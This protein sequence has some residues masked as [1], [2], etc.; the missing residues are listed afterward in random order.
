[1][2][3][4]QATG[5]VVSGEARREVRCISSSCTEG[6]EQDSCAVTQVPLA[7]WHAQLLLNT[8]P[9][10]N[11]LFSTRSDNDDNLAT[12]SLC[13]KRLTQCYRRAQGWKNGKPPKRENAH[14]RFFMSEGADVA[15]HTPVDLFIY[16]F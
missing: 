3:F 15:L 2:H 16:F 14:G 4:I 9:F 5:T 10:R 11:S 12:S 1:M 7:F 8:Y 6:A 13:M